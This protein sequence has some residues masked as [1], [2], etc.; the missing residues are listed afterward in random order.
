MAYHETFATVGT[1]KA[2]KKDNI[3]VIW[4]DG[5]AGRSAQKVTS[6]FAVALQEGRNVRHVIYW[7]D[8]CSSRNKNWT[9]MSS[10][11]CLIN[12]NSIAAEDITLKYF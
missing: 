2:N 8:N 9:L 5:V 7:M 1:K 3:A 4:H 12:S 6:A 10:L 11:V